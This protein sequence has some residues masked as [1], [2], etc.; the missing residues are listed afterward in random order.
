MIPLGSTP[1]T[2]TNFWRSTPTAEGTRSKWVIVMVRIHRALP[3]GTVAQR[4]SIGLK[5]RQL[6]F[7]S[8]R[9]HQ[10]F[11]HEAEVD[12]RWP[13]KLVVVS[14]TLTMRSKGKVPLNGRQPVSKTAGASKGA[15]VRFLHLPPHISE[16]E[17][18]GKGAA[19]LMLGSERA[20]GFESQ[21]LRHILLETWQAPCNP[22]A[23]Q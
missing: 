9:C 4:K 3:S 22:S 21:A 11:A 16:S 19:L 5:P 18:C 7:D 17:P 12:K 6:R 2:S 14:S 23:S 15:G 1:R 10:Q 13:A 20:A 8:V